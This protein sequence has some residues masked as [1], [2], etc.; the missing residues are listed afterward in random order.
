MT[1][2]DS[3]TQP[4]SLTSPPEGASGVGTIINYTISNVS[5][6]WE[7][8]KGAT[9]YQWQL[10]YDTDFSS[11]PA[12]FEGNTT[13][14]SARLPSLEPATTYYW[15]VRAT[16]PVLSP[17]SAKWSFTTSLGSDVIAPQLISPG[18]SASSVQLKPIFQ[19]STVAGAD[20]YELLVAADV[21]FAEP[22]VAKIG[23][24]AL[25]TTAWQCDID[26]DY[27]T[28][29]YWKVRAIGSGTSSAW[30]AV[31]AFTTESPPD[32]SEHQGHRCQYQSHHHRH[33]RRILLTGRSGWYIWVVPYS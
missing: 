12:G 1:Y 3:L 32:Q 16:A 17:W 25:S 21:S 11:L 27:D 20:S 31:S 10:D 4:V 13:V 29:Y 28:T 26:L 30:S 23:D 33:P 19:W 7:A 9:S 6:D 24:Y 2:S 15:R 18:A 22:I 8:L 5:L 14:T